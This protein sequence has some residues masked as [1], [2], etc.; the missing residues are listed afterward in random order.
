M[1]NHDPNSRAGQFFAAGSLLFKAFAGEDGEFAQALLAR[2]ED[3]PEDAVDT[4]ARDGATAT[5][6][7]RAPTAASVTAPLVTATSATAASSATGVPP[8]IIR[9]DECA[10]EQTIPASFGR[11]DVERLG[12]RRVARAWR[13]S[14]CVE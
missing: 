13:C 9:C 8:S 12:W 10:R 7:A 4:T 5:T 2:A 14:F 6:S 3:D 11:A 1:S